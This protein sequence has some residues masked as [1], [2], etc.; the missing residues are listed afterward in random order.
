MY[1]I[2]RAKRLDLLRGGV[3]LLAMGLIDSALL[4]HAAMSALQMALRFQQFRFMFG[5]PKRVLAALPW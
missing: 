4:A 2:K 5:W 3:V 1:D